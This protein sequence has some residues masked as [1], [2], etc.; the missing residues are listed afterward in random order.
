M[1]H[2]LAVAGGAT[3]VVAVAAYWLA[4]P[5][6]GSADAGGQRSTKIA[7]REVKPGVAE[8]APEAPPPRMVMTESGWRPQTTIKQPREWVDP[9]SGAINREVVDAVPDPEAAAREELKYRK[10][11]LRLT[12]SDAAAHCW[13]GGDSREEIE[14]EYTL[15]VENEV[16][17]ADNVRVKQSGVTNPTVERC[18]IDSVRDL[19]T[20]GDK[21][22]NMRE[23][24]G[25]IMSLHDL[26]DRNQRDAR[27]SAAAVEEKPAP[28]DRPTAKPPGE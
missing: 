17:R 5:T 6:S 18:I 23:E 21:I 9:V 14:L 16:V 8:P 28:Y 13:S 22:P 24:Q 26:Y 3:V 15:V 25:L 10:S 12:L 19:R 1:R 27:N 11:R 4:R 7:V 20:L 2:R